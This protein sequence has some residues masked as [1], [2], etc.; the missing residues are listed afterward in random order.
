MNKPFFIKSFSVCCPDAELLGNIQ[1]QVSDIDKTLIPVDM[2]RRTSMATRMAITAAKNACE[3]A[4][5]ETH[6]LPSVFASL[7]GEIQVTDSLCRSLDDDATLSPTRFLNS[8]HNTTAGYWG[9]LNHCQAATTALSAADDTFAMG[10]LE[11]CVQ[12]QSQGGNCLLVCYDELWPQYLAPP[13]G[14]FAFAC[15]LVISSEAT[16]AL[17]SVSIPQINVNSAVT[18]SKEQI[19]LAQAAPA[20][21]AIPLLLALQNKLSTWVPLNIGSLI[22]GSKLTVRKTDNS[23]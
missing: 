1:L 9:I 13:L 3:Q 15:A 21:A 6:N 7:G 23:V 2:R 10:L 20:A 4:A 5:V 11:V 8:V 12:L 16:G 14:S 18:F 17:G 19:I 22:W